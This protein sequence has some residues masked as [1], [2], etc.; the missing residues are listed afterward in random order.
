MATESK[1]APE[2]MTWSTFRNAGLELP[3]PAGGTGSDASVEP[4]S[5]MRRKPRTKSRELLF[6]QGVHPRGRCIQLN[7]VATHGGEVELVPRDDFGFRPSREDPETKPAQ[8]RR[9]PDVDPHYT[10]LAIPPRELDVRDPS[11]PPTGKVEDLAVEDVARE[12]EL[13]AGKLV[14]DRIAAYDDLFCERGYR[15]PRNP[16]VATPDAHA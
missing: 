4:C 2:A 9:C 1:D 3:R 16:A 7:L 15:R 13:V 12:Q 10:K 5:R 8:Q 6:G 11:Q 14:L